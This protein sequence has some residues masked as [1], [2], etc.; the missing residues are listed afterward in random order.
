MGLITEQEL[1]WV[2]CLVSII[3]MMVERTSEGIHSPYTQKFL[4]GTNQVF[5]PTCWCVCEGQNT[6][7][8]SL[9][10]SSLLWLCYAVHDNGLT[11]HSNTLTNHNHMVKRLLSS[12]SRRHTN[13]QL[14]PKITEI[15]SSTLNKPSAAGPLQPAKQ[16]SVFDLNSYSM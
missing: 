10:T 4:A 11:L 12:I 16:F 7:W 14:I 8:S 1:M 3:A 5:L 6:T 13:M 9:L 2:I 15:D